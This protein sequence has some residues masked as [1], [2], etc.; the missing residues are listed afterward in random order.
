MPTPVSEYL[1]DNQESELELIC[2]EELTPVAGQINY[3]Q[4]FDTEQQEDQPEH[5]SQESINQRLS[6]TAQ[7]QQ[8]YEQEKVSLKQELGGNQPFFEEFDDVISRQASEI[9]FMEFELAE[10]GLTG[11]P[12]S[13]WGGT[14]EFDDILLE[15][16]SQ[17]SEPLSK[18][19]S[20]M[21][22]EATE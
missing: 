12:V 14:Q 4:E 15:L 13:I 5:L 22:K 11:K 17:K 8:P 19:A 1:L 16:G 20:A 10:K 21:S 6:L 18:R 2:I 9:V 7:S 3:N